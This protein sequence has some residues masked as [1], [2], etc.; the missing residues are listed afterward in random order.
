MSVTFSWA[1]CDEGQEINLSNVNAVRVFDLL[2]INLRTTEG[3]TGQIDA[4]D[5]ALKCVY[6]LMII[7]NEPE[8]DSGTPTVESIAPGGARWIECGWSPG[9]LA[10][11]LTQLRDLAQAAGEYPIYYA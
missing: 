10:T 5:L 7:E 1:G 11:R 6:W 9:Y 4:A 3:L 8:L 2:E